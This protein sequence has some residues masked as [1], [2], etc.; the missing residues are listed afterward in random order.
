MSERSIFLAALDIA[1]PAQR[2]AYL[3][4]ACAADAAL[5][6]RLEA[7]L[8]SHELAGGFLEQSPVAV[9]D[10]G[11]TTGPTPAEVPAPGTRV[12]YVGDYELLEELARGGMGVVY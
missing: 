2:S 7:L 4:R 6:R 11:A 5:R 8:R 3:D 12:R 9:A 1:D 10:P